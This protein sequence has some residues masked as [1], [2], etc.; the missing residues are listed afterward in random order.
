MTPTPQ[1]D[2]ALPIISLARLVDGPGRRAELQRLRQVTHE[3]GFFYLADHGVPGELAEEL[4]R[5]T[6]RF[7]A[8]PERDKREIANIT[9]PHYRGYAHIGDEL[10][11]GRVDWRE[12]ID[13]A[14]ERPAHHG[15]PADK[16]WRVL[17]GPNL[18]P[19][20]V[21]ELKPLVG[22]WL[23]R[24]T[25]VSRQL[26]R[27]W[28][29]SLGQVP[30]FFDAVSERPFPVMKIAHYPGHDG[31]ATGQG[32]G[33]HKD[34]GV[35]TLL[36]PQPGST[37]LQVQREGKWVDV[38]ATPGLFVVNIGELLEAAT[39]GYLVAT[40]HR[41]LPPV[42]GTARYSL[43]YFFTSSLDEV[44]PQVPLP[45]ELAAAARGVGRDMAGQAISEITGVNVL[46]SR[47]RAH[48]EITERYHVDLAR[49]LKTGS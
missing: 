23:E 26:L 34:S 48:P 39:D 30:G 16:P 5:A 12:Q 7:F 38:T 8:R 27:A 40:P 1:S 36:L 35:L 21:P 3:V 28:A 20:S 49:A 41:V 43:P 13:F 46:K 6:R 18:W 9:S 10:T 4:F 45:P 37:G 14:V 47:L 31:S 24:N 17:E 44:F 19:E 22:E 32:V 42:P 29:E 25:A 15:D 11:Q 33:A 2:P